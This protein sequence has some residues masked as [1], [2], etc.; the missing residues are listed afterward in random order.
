MMVNR[1]ISCRKN[2]DYCDNLIKIFP[3]D[4]IIT[5]IIFFLQIAI[6]NEK[7]L[8]FLNIP[9]VE[10]PAFVTRMSGSQNLKEN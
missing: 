4:K 10:L 9:I 5:K 8:I 3:V 2:I 1:T 6:R 7:Y